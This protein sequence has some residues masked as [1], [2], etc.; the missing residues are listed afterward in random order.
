MNQEK[1]I[2]DGNFGYSYSKYFK[3]VKVS[4]SFFAHNPLRSQRKKKI[5]II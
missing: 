2:F 1:Y 4:E 3:L 5:L